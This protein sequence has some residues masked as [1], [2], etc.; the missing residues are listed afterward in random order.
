[1]NNFSDFADV[2]HSAGRCFA[3][4]NVCSDT[5]LRKRHNGDG[6]EKEKEE[7]VDREGRIEP[8]RPHIRGQPGSTES[9][10]RSIS[11]NLCK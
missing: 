2:Y 3:A 10:T 8:K 11:C 5:D 4:T 7:E 6:K 9:W 1:M